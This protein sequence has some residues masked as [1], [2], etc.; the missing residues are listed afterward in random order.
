MT[1]QPPL[2]AASPMSLFDDEATGDDDDDN[3]HD[4]KKNSVQWQQWKLIE[5]KNGVELAEHSLGHKAC[6]IF[7]RAV[8]QVDIVLSHESCSRQHARI[9][10]DGAT[11]TPWL[12]DLQSTH[13][14]TVNKRPLPKQA[15]RKVE[16][17]HSKDVSTGSRGVI[18]YPSDVL[19]FGAS[20]RLYCLEGPDEY[21]REKKLLVPSPDKK[22]PIYDNYSSNQSIGIEHG[23]RNGKDDDEEEEGE[24]EAVMWG[25]DRMEGT[26]EEDATAVHYQKWIDSLDETKIPSQ[27]IKDWDQ[28]RATRYKLEQSELEMTRIERK[29]QMGD[30]SEGQERQLE[31]LRDRIEQAQASLRERQ[32]R[33]HQ[34]LLPGKRLHQGRQATGQ[35]YQA[36]DDDEVED[37]TKQH[38]EKKKK[39]NASESEA[40]TEQS[41]VDKTSTLMVQE[42]QLKTR[43]K[44]AQDQ[45]SQLQLKYQRMTV[46]GKDAATDEGEAFF[47]QNNINLVQET[48]S[49]IQAQLKDNQSEMEETMQLLKIVAPKQYQ[50]VLSSMEKTK[51][52]AA[53]TTT[54]QEGVNGNEGDDDGF[55]VPAPRT[56]RIIATS[57]QVSPHAVVLPSANGALPQTRT[58]PL[59]NDGESSLFLAPPPPNKRQKRNIGPSAMLHTSQQSVSTKGTLSVVQ[60]AFHN[61]TVEPQTPAKAIPGRTMDHDLDY[62][63]KT[64]LTKKRSSTNHQDSLQNDTWRPPKDQ[65]GSG[66][67]K[68]NKKY[69]GRY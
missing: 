11:G 40:E 28:I 23:E 41:L 1:Y 25:M 67:T 16:V 13:G 65:D 24:S 38:M 2:W 26:Q 39:R 4:K 45:L 8:D 36:D 64:E 53:K 52:E 62:P 58:L 51:D 32:E 43:W 18:L 10:F 59:P 15:C 57:P 50:A 49:K 54:D 69:A 5:I 46:L 31:R 42:G 7:G 21:A 63:V 30:L 9:A 34:A 14:T 37:R 61:G 27:H 47:V 66:Y 35:E 19:W 17:D 68:L 48:I 22:K 20:T 29:G 12:M 6:V 60:T 33:L 44:E 3:D 56:A 55:V